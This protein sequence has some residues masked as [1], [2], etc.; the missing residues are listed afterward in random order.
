[1]RINTFIKPSI[2]VNI[3]ATVVAGLLALPLVAPKYLEA[4]APGKK[5]AESKNMSLVGHHDL[6]ARSAYQPVIQEQ[7]GR[8]I[9]YVGHHSG[10]APNTLLPGAPRQTNG[11]SI[12]DVTNPAKPVYLHHIPAVGG[13]QMVQTC[14]G[15]DLPRGEG[16]KIYLLLSNGNVDHQIYDVTNPRVPMFV[17]TVLSGGHATHKNWW[18]CNSGIAYINYDGRQRGWKTSRQTWV[19]DLGDP[20]HPKVIR[21]FGLPGQEPKSSAAVV[22]AGAHEATLSADGTRLY[23]AYGTSHNGVVQIVDVA[24]LLSCRPSCPDAPTVDE[25]LFPQVGRFDMPAFWGGHTAWAMIGMDVPKLAKFGQGT[26]RD[27]LVVVSESTSNECA[28]STQH[29]VFLV[30]ITDKTNPMPV[31]NYQVEESS[32][33]FCARG[34]RFGAHSM[35]WSR[36]PDFD[37]K[38]IVASWFNAGVRAIDVRDPFQPK[39]V[40]F[41]IPAVTANTDT[42]NGKVAIQTNNVEIDNRGY[43]YLADRANTGL[44]IVRLTGPAAQIVQRPLKRSK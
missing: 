28:E 39:E 16:A 34:G 7:D 37:N 1:M 31:A 23:I 25:L 13:A 21:V 24:K 41:F 18:D 26:P 27:F 36:N 20:A 30:E 3:L 8:W 22:P 42:R 44:H 19:V 33:N 2:S 35:N 32:G 5:T 17:S 38:L 11:V 10:S 12:V 15:A 43:I 40:G 4:A 14:R 6:Q 9:A 29:P